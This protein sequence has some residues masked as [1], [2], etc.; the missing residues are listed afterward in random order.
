MNELYSV[1]CLLIG[2]PP[3]LNFLTLNT[4]FGKFTDNWLN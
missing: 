3:D 2:V 1:Y 4:S